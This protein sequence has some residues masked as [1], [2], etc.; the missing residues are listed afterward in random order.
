[1]EQQNWDVMV[2]PLGEQPEVDVWSAT[3]DT[4]AGRVHGERDGQA[5]V[6]PMGQLPVFI[7]SLKQAQLFD[8]G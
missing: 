5:P 1:M 6:T 8:A 4:F 2:H 7:G 3:G